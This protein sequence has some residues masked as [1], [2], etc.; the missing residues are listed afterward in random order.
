MPGRF[1][2]GLLDALVGDFRPYRRLRGGKWE[3]ERNISVGAMGVIFWSRVDV[4]TSRDRKDFGS[5]IL[6]RE[7]YR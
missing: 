3:Y 2:M 1:V 7:D 5:C 6:R 4:W